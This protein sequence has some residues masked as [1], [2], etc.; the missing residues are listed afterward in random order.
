MGIRSLQ[1]G[2][3]GVTCIEKLGT[4]N[5]CGTKMIKNVMAEEENHFKWV[6]KHA[7]QEFLDFYI[8]FD[9]IW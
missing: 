8:A 3:G 2:G 9:A 6:W 4:T 5:V 1:K 7:F